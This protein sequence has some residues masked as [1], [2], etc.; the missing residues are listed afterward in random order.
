M[1]KILS[2]SKE[3]YL[4]PISKVKTN[5]ENFDIIID[6]KKTYQ[7]LLGFGGAFTDASSYIYSMLSEKQKKE[8]IENIF[9]EKG[10]NYNIVRLTI[11]SCD[12]SCST[13]DY[14]EEGVFSLKHDLKT[15]IPFIKKG[16]SFKDILV[17]SSPWSPPS[18][19][20]TNAKRQYGGKLKEEFYHKYALYLIDYLKSMKENGIN[21]DFMSMQNEPQAV[22]T[23]D[24]CIYSGKE[25]S[26][27]VKCLYPLIKENKLSTKIFIWD[28]NKDIIVERVKETINAEVDEYI[29]GIA[30]HWYDN[31][32]NSELSKIHYMYENK[33]LLFTEGCVELLL[34]DKDNPSKN[35][36]NFEN[37]LR[38]AKNYILD[39]EN[40][41]SGFID[42]NLILDEK[43]GPNYAGN[44]CEAPIMF[45]KKEK[46]LIYNPSYYIISH[47]SKFLSKGDIR[48]DTKVTN[49]FI[50]ATSYKKEDNKYICVLLNDGEDTT[51]NVN[52]IDEC[53]SVKLSAKSITTIIYEKSR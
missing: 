53:F 43:G 8:F 10:L 1:I 45:N 50:I 38:Y 23:W 49:P 46:E 26:N 25:E 11:G 36:G 32:C 51:V 14:L 47:F 27:L 34:L 12:F 41:S 24:S 20:K 40:F 39:S 37:G 30:Y 44:F 42:W 29:Y 6:D 35:I 19:Y 15:I 2:S 3:N 18:I 33:V 21:V 48:I 16:K 13:Y 31:F 22:Q 52:F 9:T 4:V 17:F 28:H 7:T 5:G